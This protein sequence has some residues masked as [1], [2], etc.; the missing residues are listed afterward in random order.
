MATIPD[1]AGHEFQPV[2]FFRLLAL[3]AWIL[4][5][6][7]LAWL[8]AAVI[9]TWQ[10]QEP[11]KMMILG[12]L[13]VPLLALFYWLHRLLQSYAGRTRLLLSP[14][15]IQYHSLL[16]TLETD[17]DQVTEIGPVYFGKD[18]VVGFKL[19]TPAQLKQSSWIGPASYECEGIPLRPFGDPHK[20][21]LADAI[22][23]Y[24]PHLHKSE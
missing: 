3:M 7:G 1:F 6:L 12:L 23:Q 14:D 18:K 4:P 22:G 24:A 21:A 5:G 17:W 16:Y 13:L 15:K 10:T 9:L 19:R 8:V 20:G 11:G 2:G